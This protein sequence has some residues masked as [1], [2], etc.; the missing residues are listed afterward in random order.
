MHCIRAKKKM[1]RSV[2]IYTLK[3]N[4]NQTVYKAMLDIVLR[5]TDTPGCLTA[6]LFLDGQSL[7]EFHVY[8]E[9]TLQL[10]VPY[11]YTNCGEDY[12]MV[13]YDDTEVVFPTSS[14]SY[15]TNMTL[16]WNEE[17]SGCCLVNII[18]PQQYKCPEE[19]WTKLWNMMISAP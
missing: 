4:A 15:S 5:T 9:D 10:I 13:W 18:S 17:F 3:W 14:K 2:A 6:Q 1:K 16:K 7:K 11:I 12:F 8:N 19:F